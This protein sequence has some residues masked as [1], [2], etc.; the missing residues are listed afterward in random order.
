MFILLLLIFLGLVFFFVTMFG[1]MITAIVAIIVGV[2][3]ITILAS[4]WLGT[5]YYL[6][7]SGNKP[8]IA[9]ETYR[10]VDSDLK[11]IVSDLQE[12]R[13][14]LDDAEPR[15]RNMEFLKYARQNRN[16]ENES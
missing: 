1:A 7:E 3:T 4:V 16:G 10:Q 2:T 13:S 6:K 14:E 12:I 8:K 15:L 5:S 9:Q 11:Q